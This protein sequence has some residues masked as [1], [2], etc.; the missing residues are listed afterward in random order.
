MRM[1][2]TSHIVNTMNALKNDYNFSV[3]IVLLSLGVSRS[4]ARCISSFPVNPKPVIAIYLY[5]HVLRVY[6][7]PTTNLN[8]NW[9][10]R[11]QTHLRCAAQIYTLLT[12]S[13][14]SKSKQSKAAHEQIDEEAKRE[15]HRARHC[16]ECETV[17]EPWGKS[18][19]HQ[20]KPADR[21]SV[22][23]CTLKM[24]RFNNS[25]WKQH[26]HSHNKLQSCAC[27]FWI[28]SLRFIQFL[29]PASE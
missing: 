4:I 17:W 13:Q 19:W 29:K 16:N 5:A 18:N 8:V 10:W 15:R 20:K 11:T 1:K 12:S 3:E 21:L 22:V 27:M 7:W 9:S 28:G 2:S 26:T 14:S 25:R 24:D 23:K 6:F